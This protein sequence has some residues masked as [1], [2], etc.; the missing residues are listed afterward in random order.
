MRKDY[1]DSCG[2]EIRGG[3]LNLS[4][5]TATETRG[6]ADF[7]LNM[8]LCILCTDIVKQKI[9]SMPEVA[10]RTIK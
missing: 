7:F 10:R 4:A 2:D 6:D 3:V 8:D 9:L 5:R 1:C